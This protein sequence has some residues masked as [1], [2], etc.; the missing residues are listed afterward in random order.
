MLGRCNTLLRRQKNGTCSLVSTVNISFFLNKLQIA[1]TDIITVFTFLLFHV[2]T[3]LF[4][5]YRFFK[6]IFFIFFF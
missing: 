2:F 6:F 5:L 3:T 4:Y 1:D